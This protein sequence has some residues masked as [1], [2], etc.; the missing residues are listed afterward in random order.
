MIGA[1]AARNTTSVI[2]KNHAGGKGRFV[3]F[4]KET[5]VEGAT[6]ASEARFDY[7]PR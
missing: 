7:E 1:F 5:K 3:I 6:F 2:S 4:E